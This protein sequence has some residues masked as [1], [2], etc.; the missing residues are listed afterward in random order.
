MSGPCR[1][2][3]A[4]LLQDVTCPRDEKYELRLMGT[5]AELQHVQ[6]AMYSSPDAAKAAIDVELC[7]STLQQMGTRHLRGS[8]QVAD[9]MVEARSSE[10]YGE[11]L[12]A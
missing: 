1:D 9:I 5:L 2:S 7:R 4:A 8:K 6:R 11:L 10:G 12:F 3:I